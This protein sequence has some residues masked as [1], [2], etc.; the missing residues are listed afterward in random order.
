[1]IGRPREIRPK[2]LEGHL[3]FFL[4]TRPCLALL[5][6][7]FEEHLAPDLVWKLGCHLSVVPHTGEQ[8]LEVSGVRSTVVREFLSVVRP[9]DVCVW[10][11]VI[12]P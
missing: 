3:L 7:V 1:M 9:Q 4:R 11:N 12:A 6:E 5:Q 8:K 2:Q 10:E